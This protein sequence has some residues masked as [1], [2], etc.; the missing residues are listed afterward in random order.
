MYPMLLL[1]LAQAAELAAVVPP[2]RIGGPNVVSLF[3]TDDYPKEAAAH[4]WQGTV[5][6]E[7]TVSPEGRV[8]ACDI[9]QSSG[10]KV[11]DDKTCDIL[12]AR[13]KFIPAR[14]AKGRPTADRLR[15]PPIVWRIAPPGPSPSLND[16]PE[17]WHGRVEAKL[18]VNPQGTVAACHVAKSSGNRAVDAVTCAFLAQRARFTPVRDHN[19]NA[20]GQTVNE[21]IEW[22][23]Q[24]HGLRMTGPPSVRE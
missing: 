2:P 5:V 11:L 7:V 10:H 18:A 23:I 19:G 21:T 1:L 8:S 12:F 24:D 6:A 9:V 22:R 4:G 15:T 3:S 14:D 20:A 16:L 17:G 13:A